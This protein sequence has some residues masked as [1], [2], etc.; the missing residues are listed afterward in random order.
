MKH[1]REGSMSFINLMKNIS[2]LRRKGFLQGIFWTLISCLLSNINDVL[3]KFTSSHLNPFQIVFFRSLLGLIIITPL[4]LLK[5]KSYKLTNSIIHTKRIVVGAAAITLAC[6]STS[7]LSLPEV[8][9]LSFC[10]PLFFLP[11]AVLFLREKLTTPRVLANILGFTGVF[12]VLGPENKEFLSIASFAPLASA[13]LFMILDII[14]K[15]SVD[16]EHPLALIFYFNLGIT[17]LTG[18]FTLFTWETPTFTELGLLFLLGISAT[19]I[20]FSSLLSLSAANILSL[21]PLRYAELLF[22]CMFSL[23]LFNE[24]PTFYVI[25][26][27]ILIIVAV[28]YA[29]FNESRS[30]ENEEKNVKVSE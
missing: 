17:L 22:S 8:T 28:L 2:C 3:M 18:I 1:Y 11:A 13:F 27:S 25:L 23:L 16:L 10:Q 12:V 4:F 9:V 26:G 20:Q 15:K 24:P 7:I 5:H 14:T 6:Y 21:A 30:V 29:S 19:L